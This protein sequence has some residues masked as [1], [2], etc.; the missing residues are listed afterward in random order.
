MDCFTDKK[1]SQ[2]NNRGMS[3][4]EVI[5][6]VVI[7]TV[8][9]IPL[10][11][12]FVSAARYNARA[13]ERQRVTTVAQSV[14]EGF[15]AYGI[16]DL[17]MQFNGAKPFLLYS[18][19]DDYAEMGIPSIDT[20]GA[21]P[22]FV[23]HADNRYEFA[24]KGLLVDG[25]KYD[26]YVE[27]TPMSG[28]DMAS[29]DNINKYLDAVYRQD[30][31]QDYEIYDKILDNIT[32]KLNAYNTDPS[33]PVYEESTKAGLDT[34]K[35]SVEKTTV[36][37]I[38]KTEDIY[39]VTVQ[40]SY[41]YKVENYELKKLDGTT[42]IIASFDEV[43]TAAAET[44]YDNTSTKSEGAA[45]GNLYYFYY[46]AYNG[47]VPF[48]SERIVF[49]NNTGEQKTIYLV[50]QK[51][52]GISDIKITTLDNIYAPAIEGNNAADIRL[53]HNLNSH[54]ISGSPLSRAS[55]NGVTPVPDA[56]TAVSDFLSEKEEILL[57][58]V[59]VSAYA[60]GAAADNFTGHEVLLRLDGSMNGK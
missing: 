26:A 23:P 19:V 51:T 10:L 60:E 49:N 30:M 33:A 50:K 46:P 55:F 24:I 2:L 16:E 13:R 21:V 44:V 38:N 39:T 32:D 4:V 15:K 48:S 17:C 57:Y 35:I 1:R 22:V 59:S 37:A 6:A 9:M 20:S 7:L 8:V 34:D 45:L 53:Y 54:I 27:V 31:Q 58:K 36:V 42:E 47:E 56:E 11:Q 14:M 3:L 12:T 18:A 28:Y 43:I 5:I 52:P 40:S 29:V 41:T 25:K